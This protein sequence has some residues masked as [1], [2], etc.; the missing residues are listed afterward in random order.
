MTQDAN[1]PAPPG[2][3]ADFSYLDALRPSRIRELARGRSAWTSVDVLAGDASEAH[4]IRAV[5]E[6]MG[7][8]VQVFPLGL[9]QH[10]VNVLSGSVGTGEYLLLACHGDE[11]AIVLPELAP[12]VAATQR[13][14]TRLPADA[15]REIVHLPDRTVIGLGCD[16]GH[17]AL[18]DAFLGGGCRAY[19]GPESGPFRYASALFPALL[20][21]ELTE[22]RSLA[23]AVQR[24]RGWDAEMAMWRLYERPPSP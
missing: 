10:A 19:I 14:H 15:V 16:M 6:L 3:D 4:A 1:R 22:L 7:I 2:P 8:H 5:L 12:E 24:I 21:Y 20:F 18:A 13:W 9:A 11:G 23:D 17:P